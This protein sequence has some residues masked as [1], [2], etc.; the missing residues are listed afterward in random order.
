MPR[1]PIPNTVHYVSASLTFPSLWNCTDTWLQRY[2]TSVPQTNQDC[3]GYSAL[4]VNFRSARVSDSSCTWRYQH[5]AFRQY[6]TPVPGQW[7]A[8]EQRRKW[9]TSFWRK[10]SAPSAPPRGPFVHTSCIFCFVSLWVGVLAFTHIKV[11]FYGNLL[12]AALS[13][14]CDRE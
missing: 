6:K 13:V 7:L 8:L 3:L 4:A 1:R 14:C 5:C 11:M 9:S 10:L 2:M 12:S